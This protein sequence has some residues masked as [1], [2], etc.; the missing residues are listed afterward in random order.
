MGLDFEKD[1]IKKYC[2]WNL[3][4]MAASFIVNLV[5]LILTAVLEDP[6]ILGTLGLIIRLVLGLAV[7]VMTI[8]IFICIIKHKSDINKTG[9]IMGICLFVICICNC[10][11]AF[12]YI[13]GVCLLVAEILLNVFLPKYI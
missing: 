11:F 6:G 1:D 3:W 10:A 9:F 5:L 13:V 7:L 12:Q 4:C 8:F 2:K